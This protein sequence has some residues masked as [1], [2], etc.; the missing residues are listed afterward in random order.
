MSATVLVCGNMFDGSSEDLSGPAEILVEGNLI[1]SIW[2]I[3]QPS[4]R[5]AGNRPFRSD[6]NPWIH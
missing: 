2:A 4:A 3:C 5:S 1:A 6:S